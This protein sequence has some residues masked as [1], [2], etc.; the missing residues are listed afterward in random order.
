MRSTIA[1]LGPDEL[2]SLRPQVTLIRI[3]DVNFLFISEQHSAIF[4]GYRLQILQLQRETWRVTRL[5]ASIQRGTERLLL[6][7]VRV[8]PS[9]TVVDVYV[10]I[11][12]LTFQ[13]L[14]EV[15]CLFFH[16]Q[17]VRLIGLLEQGAYTGD[18]VRADKLL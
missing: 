2:L 9:L 18:T 14:H 17:L 7:G 15:V 13:V 6:L 16:R 3:D 5:L 8:Q 12:L 10:E 1:S 11:F 4:S